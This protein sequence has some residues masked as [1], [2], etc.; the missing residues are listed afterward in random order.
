MGTLHNDGA[1]APGTVTPRNDEALA[2][3]TAQGF[4]Q[5]READ[6]RY[7]AQADADRK[8]FETLRALLALKGHALHRTHAYDGLVRFYVTRW[9]Q[10]REL[11]DMAAV[12][13]FSEQV[14]ATHA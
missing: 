4:K 10:V 12:L 7:C 8:W 2:G 3:R 14:G 13:A 6:T 9:G 5:N 1:A 11:Q